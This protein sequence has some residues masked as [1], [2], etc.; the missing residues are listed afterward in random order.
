VRYGHSATTLLQQIHHKPEGELKTVLALSPAY[1]IAE[2]K[3]ARAEA[4]AITGLFANSSTWLDG[5]SACESN[6]SQQASGYRILHFAAHNFADMAQPMQSYISLTPEGKEDGNLHAWEVMR[7]NLQA[8]MAV[9]SACNTGNGT[10]QKG[11]G[12]MGIARAFFV[13]GCP[14][15]TMS[16]WGLHDDATADLMVDY[17]RHL[18]KGLPPDEAL[19]AAKIQALDRAKAMAGDAASEVGDKYAHPYFWASTV[20]VGSNKLDLGGSNWLIYAMAL[21][22]LLFAYWLRNEARMRKH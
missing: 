15:V 13:A 4:K 12:V 19:Q 18:K 20:V 8:E 22:G 1:E 21:A 5:A 9:L 2:L 7:L 14:T 3:Q 11:E 10:I 17:Y 6:L 16:L